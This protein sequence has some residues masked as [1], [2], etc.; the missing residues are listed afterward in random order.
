MAYKE[1]KTCDQRW[2][3]TNPQGLEDSG[4]TDG[5][6]ENIKTNAQLPQVVDAVAFRAFEEVPGGP[7]KTISK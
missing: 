7:T 5:N 6:T 4:M 2:K 1:C 3:C